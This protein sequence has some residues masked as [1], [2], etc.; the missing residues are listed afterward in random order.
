MVKR[1][2]PVSFSTV[3]VSY[4][5]LDDAKGMTRRV[6]I[7]LSLFDTFPETP[8]LDE[9]QRYRFDEEAGKFKLWVGDVFVQESSTSRS[10]VDRLRDSDNL[11]KRVFSILKDLAGAIMYRK[12]MHLNV[13][14]DLIRSS[15]RIG[16]R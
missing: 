15:R 12:F 3:N 11:M 2:R 10:L 8:S 9:E 7:C 6:K 5:S 13:N 14:S 1:D 4:P 16:M